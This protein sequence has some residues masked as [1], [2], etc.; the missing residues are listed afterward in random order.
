M[1]MGSSDQILVV[2]AHDHGRCPGVGGHGGPPLSAAAHRLPWR[3]EIRHDGS[4]NGQDV[5]RALDRSL[6]VTGAVV[7]G[8]EPGQWRNPT[9]CTEL[10][11]RGVLNHLV[12]S[13]LRFAAI[14][15]GTSG[16][17][18]AADV[19]G[20]DPVAAYQDAARRLRDA[21]AQPDVLTTVYEAPFGT[22][23]GSWMAMV[24]VIEVLV[25]GWDIAKG[26][27]QH[28]DFPDDI[29]ERALEESRPQLIT[30]PAGPGAAF[31]PEVEIV[32]DAPAIDRL[33]AFLGRR[34]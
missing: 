32:G 21:F 27:G 17:D 29:A 28:A 8:V 33:A 26:T 10:D 9:P 19:L 30:R 13:N 12:G 34:P 14:L 7:A 18:R 16:P 3:G 6:D 22:A 5:L 15:T 20:D 24:R 23:P 11:V 2:S 31:A 25:H 1:I 4:V